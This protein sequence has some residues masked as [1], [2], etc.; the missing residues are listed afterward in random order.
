MKSAYSNQWLQTFFDEQLPS[1]KEVAEKLLKHSFEIEEVRKVGDDTVYELDI[2]PNRSVDCLAHYGIA[3]EISAIFSLPL[4]KQ[5]PQE[6][7]V[8]KET[9]EYIHTEKCDRYTILK[10][11]NITLSETPEEIQKHLESIGQRCIHPIVDLSNYLLFDIGQP[12]HTFDARKVS[13]QFSVRKAKTNE[14]LVLLGGE[15]VTLH[16]DDVVI[17]DACNDKPIALAGVKGGEETK[18]DEDTKDIYIEIATFDSVSVRRVMRRTG[19]VSDAALRFS[20]G[21]PPIMIGYAAQRVVEV[22]GAHSSITNSFDHRRVSLPKQHKISISVPEINN[23]LGT[24][25]TQKEVANTLDRLGFPYRYLDQQKQYAMTIPVERPDI[26]DEHDVI[27]EVGRVLGYDTVPSILPASG[28]LQALRKWI[29]NEILPRDEEIFTKRLAVV[30]TLQ[31]IGFSEVMTSSFCAKGE[32]CVAYPVA[33]DKGCLR[34][35]LRPGIEKAL[36]KNAYNGELLGLGAIQIAE[37]G[38][39][40][41]KEGEK[42][43]L[44]LGVRETAGRT[45]VNTKTIEKMVRKVLH[46]P[47]GFE[48][49][50]WEVALEKVKTPDPDNSTLWKVGLHE[51]RARNPDSTM[52]SSSTVQYVP[53]SKYPFVLRDVAV[54]MPDGVDIAE[55]EALLQ[56]NGGKYLQK[57]NLFDSFEKDGKQSHAF[58]LVFQSNKKTLDD[59]EVN[60][61][62]DSIYKALQQSRYEVR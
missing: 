13:G 7:Y 29:R 43:H 9:A 26:Q 10:A 58:R 22:F 24:T 14:Q 6:Q 2:L 52:P 38:S 4:K 32:V 27:E 15:T 51:A 37:I 30:R 54:F 25:Y 12:I 1:P 11:E 47:G 53:P 23:L 49:G 61:Q 35:S 60:K 42:V 33:K 46:M 40:F 56:K 48:N 21:I 55:T 17:T 31:S 45:K 57:I 36:D 59:E 16:E 39:V 5:Y 3:K 62:M 20:Q 18:V 44:A 8:Y 41:T 19:Y 28:I 50:V 34:S